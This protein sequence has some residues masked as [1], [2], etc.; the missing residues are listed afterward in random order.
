MSVQFNSPWSGHMCLKVRAISREHPE[1]FRLY[2]EGAYSAMEWQVT[3]GE[4]YAFGE[5][6]PSVTQ[7]RSGHIQQICRMNHYCL[8][9]TGLWPDK[10]TPQLCEASVNRNGGRNPRRPRR[11]PRLVMPLRGRG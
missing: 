4:S 10:V 1:L 11:W 8:N 9:F 5:F 6:F 7:S 3:N 2:Q